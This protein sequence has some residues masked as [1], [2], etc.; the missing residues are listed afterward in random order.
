MTVS[1]RGLLPRMRRRDPE[2]QHRAASPLELFFD[3]VFVVAVS[4]S[5]QQLHHM[6]ADGL[7]GQAV[8]GYLMVFF[9]IW[10]A[11]MNFTW[12][13]TSFDTDDWL[14]RVMTI[15]QMAGVLVLA[16]G[17]G[18]AM[19]EHDF[20]LVTL[21]YVIMRLALVV[22][23]IR[24]ALEDPGVRAVALRY[25]VGV[26]LVQVAWV[27]RLALPEAAG[28]IVFFVLVAAEI[29]VPVWAESHGG[30][31]WNPHHITE[32][33]SLFTLILLGESILASANAAVEAFDSGHHV[34]SLVA[35]SSAGLVIA[36]GMWWI[37]FSRPQ[38]SFVGSLRSSLTYGY[39]HYVIFAAAG[40]FSA[41]VEVAIDGIEDETGTGSFAAAGTLTIPVALFAVSIWALVL[42]HSLS[43]AE[44]VVFL[45]GVVLVLVGTVLP[46]VLT[47]VAAAVGIIVAARATE[48]GRVGHGVVGE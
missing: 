22:Q 10:W 15:V 6:E 5:S 46:G 42:R 29:S 37:Y 30:T 41:G 9:A 43:A 21:G 48:R 16:A 1:G 28:F 35:V 12:F 4:F 20:A 38:H 44:N 2:E 34:P 40:A 7:L 23:W 33:Y 26:T 25:A 31:P 47:V 3:L 27:A 8:L 36:A 13:A 14:Y 24:A 45:V 18:P 39:F 11:W 17:T 19:E 32:R